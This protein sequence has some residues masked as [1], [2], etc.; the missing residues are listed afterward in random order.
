LSFCSA[1]YPDFS[2]TVRRDPGGDPANTLYWTYYPVRHPDNQDEKGIGRIQSGKSLGFLS[3][4]QR[5]VT[6]GRNQRNARMKF[7]S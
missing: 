2:A 6:V 5:P 3:D 1:D 7:L 4:P